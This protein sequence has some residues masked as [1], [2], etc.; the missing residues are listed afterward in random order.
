MSCSSHL[1][2]H[3]FILYFVSFLN[4]LLLVW[5]KGVWIVKDI[6]NLMVKVSIPR[7]WI[8]LKAQKISKE[9]QIKIQLIFYV[10]EQHC[11]ESEA[12]TS[13]DHLARVDLSAGW[14]IDCPMRCGAAELEAEAQ[15]SARCCEAKVARKKRAHAIVS[16]TSACSDTFI[17]RSYEE[18]PILVEAS[19][20]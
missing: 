13:I 12:C 11:G 16:K 9:I 18:C 20:Q 4:L 17:D 5:M 8:R 1:I 3:Y 15:S 2:L 7:S 10:V 6:E 19:S 14:S